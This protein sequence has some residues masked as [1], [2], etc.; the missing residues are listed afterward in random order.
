[1]FLKINTP[2]ERENI[3]IRGIKT[4]NAKFI[5]MDRNEILGGNCIF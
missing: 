2:E 4:S 3:R 5:L 1:M